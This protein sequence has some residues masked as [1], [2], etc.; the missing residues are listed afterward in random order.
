MIRSGANSRLITECRQSL[1]LVRTLSDEQAKRSKANGGS[2]AKSQNP[3]VLLDQA[4]APFVPNSA[5]D[6][7]KVLADNVLYHSVGDVLVVD[8][9]YGG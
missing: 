7:A 9:P 5:R 8:K 6:L 3:K 4:L 2:E 1:F